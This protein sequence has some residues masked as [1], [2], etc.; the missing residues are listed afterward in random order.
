MKGRQT[1]RV[2]RQYSEA[3][4]RQVVEEL[5][6]K[7][8]SVAEAQVRYGI[9]HRA[10]I[11]AWRRKYGTYPVVTKVVRVVMKSEKDRIRELEEALADEKI[12]NRLLQAELEIWQEME[13]KGELK[14]KPGTVRFVPSGKKKKS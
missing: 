1:V 7:Q 9:P 12:R 8:V 5:E 6:R 4:K 3:L 14:K 11:T 10:T 2:Q 13:K